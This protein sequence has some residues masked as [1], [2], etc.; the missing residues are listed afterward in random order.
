MDYAI[1]GKTYWLVGASAGIGAAL[2]RELDRR[3]AKL[4]LSARS[5]EGLEAVAAT[6]TQPAQSVPMDVTDQTSV[7]RTVETLKDIDGVIYVAGD[8]APMSAATWEAARAVT[9]SA[10]NYTG[11][12]NVLGAL[13]PRFA[14]HDRGHVVIVGSLAGFSGLPGA[15]GYGDSK[16]A[17]MH[18]VQNLRVDLKASKVRLQLINPGFVKT[19][20]TEKNEFRMPFIME[21]E[22][23]AQIMADHMETNRFSKSFPR[24]FSWVFKARGILEIIRM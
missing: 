16:A 21:P 9:V 13:V 5:K 14:R 3:G 12:L 10:I 1:K 18:L 22:K 19:R 7:S 20:L 4:V 8:Y 23:A 15:V 2:A 6:L 11:A 24:L 17:L